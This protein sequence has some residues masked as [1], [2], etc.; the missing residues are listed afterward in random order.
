MDELSKGMTQTGSATTTDKIQE[1]EGSSPSVVYV[2][3]LCWECERV[4]LACERLGAVAAAPAHDALPPPPQPPAAPSYLVT[5]PFEGELFDAAHKA[6]YR[7]VAFDRFLPENVNNNRRLSE[8][9]I[10]TDTYSDAF[11]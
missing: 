3:E 9:Q 5:A 8:S 1:N 7:L 4:R 6:K 10:G 2:S 11:A